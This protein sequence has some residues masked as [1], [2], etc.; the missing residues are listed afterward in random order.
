MSARRT[1]LILLVVAA[2]LLVV[3]AWRFN[4]L[5]WARAEHDSKVAT[6]SAWELMRVLDANGDGHLD[7]AEWAELSNTPM[8]GWDQDGDGRVDADELREGAWTTSPLHPDHRGE[9]GR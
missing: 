2:A 8:A 6:Q 3:A 9:P 7:E 5:R 1:T 4:T